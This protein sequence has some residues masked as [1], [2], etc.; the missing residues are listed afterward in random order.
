MPNLFA[1]GDDILIDK[2]CQPAADRLFWTWE[3]DCF[4]I[5][6]F[7]T[8]ISAL[9]WIV[10]QARGVVAAP[11]TGP[12]GI[13]VFQFALIMI[14]L[15]AIMTVRCLF[16]RDGR[17]GGT[18]RARPFNPLRAKMFGHR[19]ICILG[20]VNLLVQTILSPVEIASV[21]S[22]TTQFF[23][24][25]AVFMGACSNRPPAHREHGFSDERALTHV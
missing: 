4:R 14:G 12:S 15:G 8:D 1:R 2:L 23:L 5:A 9:A 3:I 22:L 20:L 17:A 24:T 19:L 21:A 7:C 13:V 18:S 10:S 16:E 6:R 11:E 25:T